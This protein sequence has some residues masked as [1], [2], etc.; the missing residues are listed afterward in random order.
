MAG[1]LKYLKQ[2]NILVS[3]RVQGVF[4]RSQTKNQA[5]RLGLTGW[6]KNLPDGKVEIVAQGKRENLEKLIAWSRKGPILAK[7]EK[8]EIKWK[9]PD[10]FFSSFEVIF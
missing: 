1:N 5:D 4:F 7:V 6:V 10:N 9:E 8:L 3:G 2:V